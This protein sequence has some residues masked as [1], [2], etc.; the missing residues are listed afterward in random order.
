MI[1]VK[2]LF[3]RVWMRVF[4]IAKPTQTKHKTQSNRISFAWNAAYARP[5]IQCT[6]TKRC[7]IAL[8]CIVRDRKT[9]CTHASINEYTHTHKTRIWIN[10]LPNCFWISFRYLYSVPPST[11]TQIARLWQIY[12]RKGERGN[13]QCNSFFRGFVMCSC[14][15]LVALI[16]L[17]VCLCMSIMLP[18]ILLVEFCVR[19]KMR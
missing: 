15:L 17:C 12:H 10:S 16:C 13:Q 1:K 6:K 11:H 4:S 19:L 2:L 8:L 7:F 3:D 5:H 9:K 18:Q 14:N